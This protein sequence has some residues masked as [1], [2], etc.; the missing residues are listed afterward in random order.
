MR[1]TILNGF[2]CANTDEIVRECCHSILRY[3]KF[4]VFCFNLCLFGQKIMS[5]GLLMTYG[6]FKIVNQSTD[7]HVFEEKDKSTNRFGTNTV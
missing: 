4:Y 3:F 2:I 7:C 6:N 5:N 1:S